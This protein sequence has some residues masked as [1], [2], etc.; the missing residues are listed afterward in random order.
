MGRGMMIGQRNKRNREG[1]KGT[2]N[3]RTRARELF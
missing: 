2:E 3:G 1:D